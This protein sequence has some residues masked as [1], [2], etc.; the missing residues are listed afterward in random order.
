MAT[1]I[2]KFDVGQKLW[3][4]S[5]SGLMSVTVNRIEVRVFNGCSSITYNVFN[6]N[7]HKQFVLESDL[8]ETKEELIKSL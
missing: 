3:M 5:S 1:V 7:L 6:D 2:T 8:F 4:V